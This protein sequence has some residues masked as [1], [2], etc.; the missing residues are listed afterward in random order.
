M[1]IS[2]IVDNH[3]SWFIRFSE[4]LKSK[5]GSFGTVE[6]F[7]SACQIPIGNDVA[8]LL[9]CEKIVDGEILRRSKNNIVVHASELPK[10]KGMSPLTWQILEG[11]NRIPISLFEA[12]EEVDAGQVYIRG[13]I[14]FKGN[15]L[16]QEM[17]NVLGNMIIK[18][19]QEF[20]SKWPAIVLQGCPQIGASSFYRRRNFADTEID[21][22][23][24]ISEQFD[25]LR[26]IDNE[27]YPAH[28]EWRG[29][30]YKLKIETLE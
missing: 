24:S 4:D 10:G 27:T 17:Q 2:V 1:K 11:K 12:V 15:E 8:F 30:R 14:E 23:K 25:L 28:F 13:A 18:M 9:S 19:C 26:V 22:K 21:P 16:L 6:F 7:S 5:L 20:L 3:Q 29:R